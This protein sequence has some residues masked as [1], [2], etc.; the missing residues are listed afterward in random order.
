MGRTGLQKKPE[1]T[2]KQSEALIDWNDPEIRHLLYYGGARSGKTFFVCM[3]II[4]RAVVFPESNHLICRWRGTH[5]KRNLY[6]QTFKP[7]IRAMVPRDKYHPNEKD[8]IITFENGS[9]ILL[10]GLDDAERTEGIVMGSA[11]GTIFI[12]ES[13][14]IS[15]LTFQDVKSRLSQNIPGMNP[16]LVADTNPKGKKNWVRQY[17][18]VGIDPLTNKSTNAKKGSRLWLPEDNPHITKE[19]IENELDTLSGAKKLQLRYG[20]WADPE[21][22]VYPNF[23]KC[24]VKPYPIPE[25]APTFSAIDFGTVHKF[26]CSFFA[27]LKDE[28]KIVKYKEFWFVRRS[29]NDICPDL[30]DEGILDCEFVVTDH[31][32]GEIQIIEDHGIFGQLADKDIAS[33]VDVLN[34]LIN[35]NYG[36]KYEIFDTCTA[37]IDEGLNV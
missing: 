2:A 27:Y 13:V 10:S 22:L 30:I 6:L 20:E 24:I 12:N 3:M 19:Y 36:I 37:T 33:G 7:L 31:S 14:Q 26:A 23:G 21:G 29:L 18:I 35:G 17:F 8:M 32:A 28:N 1:L 15:Y 9:M 16:L 5:L 11:Y 4:T 34:S 25:D